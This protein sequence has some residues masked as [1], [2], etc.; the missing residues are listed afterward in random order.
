MSKLAAV[1]GRARSPH[2]DPEVRKARVEGHE[3]FDMLWQDGGWSRGQ[4]YRWLGEQMGYTF[5]FGES[6]ADDCYRAKA[7][8]EKKLEEMGVL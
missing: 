1:A 3:V 5:H 4:A 8:C 6:G 7:I 2:P